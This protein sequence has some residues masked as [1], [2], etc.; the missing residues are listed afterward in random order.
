MR[1]IIIKLIVHVLY[2]VIETLYVSL[3]SHFDTGA[4]T[5]FVYVIEH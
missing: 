4:L 5:T 3:L 1:K 2:Y